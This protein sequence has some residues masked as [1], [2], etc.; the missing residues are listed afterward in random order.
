MR[1]ADLG[2]A[3]VNLA[4]PQ[5]AIEEYRPP[6]TLA[7]AEGD[8]AT[9]ARALQGL[10]RCLPGA[11]RA[12]AALDLYEQAL[13]LWPPGDG[14]LHRANRANTLHDLGV[15]YARYLGEAGR[16]R[17]WL[18]AG[19]RRLAG[20]SPP[21][22]AFTLNQLGQVAWE[23]GR[24]AEARRRYE[25]SLAALGD[26]DPCLGAVILARLAQVDAAEGRRPAAEA[27]VESAT[28]AA[29]E[30]ACR[31]R[32]RRSVCS[33]PTSPSETVTGQRPSGGSSAAA[34]SSLSEETA[35]VRR[36]P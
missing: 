21:Q 25:A 17:A 6:S 2:A 4:E 1:R 36:S 29:G 19:A 31:V 20:A 27:R 12:A 32:R 11:G 7:R 24:S 14:D 26:L 16:G 3:L 22:R 10:G 5:A 33:P 8:R 35:T 9:E 30:A 15:L 18:R 23:E 34:C 28:A 13:P